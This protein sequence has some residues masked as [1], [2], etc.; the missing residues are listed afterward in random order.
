MKLI[1][2]IFIISILWASNLCSQGFSYMPPQPKRGD[3]VKI[4]YLSSLT[5]LAGA[6]NIKC[7]GYFMINSVPNAVELPVKQVGVEYSV[8]FQF[9]SNATLGLFV[10]SGGEEITDNNKNNGYFIQCYERN[11]DPVLG[12]WLDM[13]KIYQRWANVVYME[14]DQSKFRKFAT[15]EFL[16]YPEQKNVEFATYLQTFNFKDSLEKQAVM[17][18]AD[19]LTNVKTENGTNLENARTIYQRLGMQVIA[20]SLGK[21]ILEKF[22]SDNAKITSIY[23]DFIKIS[24]ATDKMNIYTKNKELLAK[25]NDTKERMITYLI[26]DFA[27]KNDWKNFD[28]MCGEL[29]SKSQLY[30][31]YNSVAW[32]IYESKKN[33]PKGLAL[34]KQATD[35]AKNEIEKPT[36]KEK[37]YLTPSERQQERRQTFAMYA[38]TYSH[39]LAEKKDFKNA[40][41]FAQ[42]AVK[43]SDA[44][45]TSINEAYIILLEKNKQNDSII[46][47]SEKLFALGKSTQKI[48]EI[49]SK[50][51]IAK[52]KTEKGLYENIERI[53]QPAKARAFREMQRKMI[54]EAAPEFAL[55]NLKGDTLSLKELKG[56]VVVLDFWATWCGP[57]KASFP[58]MQKAVDK[59]A[60]DT[61]VIFLFVNTW[62]Q[63]EDKLSN[64]YNFITKN[65]YR[66]NVLIDNNNKVVENF[67][68]SG[69]PTKII[70]DTK[71][72][73]QFKSVGFSGNNDELIEELDRMIAMCIK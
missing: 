59:Y 67:R 8:E 2:T 65:N 40:L 72:K 12:A 54:N 69:I 55:E 42:E 57:C 29:A 15:Q 30:G 32:K 19:S 46:S 70:I 11:G 44:K 21:I 23:T 61:N 9:Q 36:Q 26:S 27:Q 50:A 4:T 39:L 22:P 1:S 73:T 58:A 35:F 25:N 6:N 53:S 7:V 33:I 18:V 34:S 56:K 71:G 52:N 66:F 37:P 24:S 38:D 20:D 16:I 60:L 47:V 62:E 41:L 10:F 48:T 64:A 3:K 49:Y 5:K 45:E 63:A 31:L 68:I 13:A 43:M 14:S 17:R 28:K 51:Y